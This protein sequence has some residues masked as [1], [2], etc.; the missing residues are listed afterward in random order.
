MCT[1]VL[2]RDRP[3]VDREIKLQP[4][5]R[6]PREARRFVAR[7]LPELGYPKLVE[8]G[9]LIVS[10]LV[11]N[12]IAAA[13]DTPLWV[14]LRLAGSLVVLEVWDCSSEDPVLRSLDCDAEG[15]RGLQ[16]VKELS[17]A[18]D[19]DTFAGGKVVWVLLG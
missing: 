2:E 7:H 18:F 5:P 19:W 17:V 14:T 3:S 8:D 12:S 13:P 10:E 6:A 15:G 9:E 11:T 1:S 4:T 16:V